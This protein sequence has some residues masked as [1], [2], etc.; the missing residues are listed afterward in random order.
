MVELRGWEGLRDSSGLVRLRE[1]P[2]TPFSS[3]LDSRDSKDCGTAVV[4][5]NSG[6]GKDCG[7]AVV[8]WD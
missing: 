4:W 8:W 3:C 5:W 6:N 1:V 2:G 7:T